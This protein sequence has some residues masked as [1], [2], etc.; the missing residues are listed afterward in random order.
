MVLLSPD[1]RLRRFTPAAAKLLNLLPTDVDRPLSDIR[2][3]LRPA[4]TS[5]A[6][7]LEAIETVT[8]VEREVQDRQ[9]CWYSL[10][11]RPYKTR[12]NQIDGAVMVLVDIDALKRGAAEVA[13]ARDFADAI[14][15]TVR[16][17]L[18]VLDA[19]PAGGAGRTAPSTTPSRCRPEETEGRFLY[20]LGNRQWDVP[21]LREAAAS[22]S[23]PRSAEIQSFEVGA[24]VPGDRPPDDGAQRAPGRRDGRGAEKI[25]VAMEDR[26]EVKK[27]E[28]ERAR[29]SPASRRW[30]ARPRRP[31]GSRTSS[32]PRS[33]TSCAAP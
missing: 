26:T 21:A 24:R 28:E 18:L 1:L 30:P 2:L 22:P 33:R 11:I 12:D 17:P 10:R 15:E 23:S 14:V 19:E 4:R 13:E 16:E 29:C 31:A 8:A 6:V 3:E 9:G 7:I 5:E 27:V 20:E 25:L 32:W